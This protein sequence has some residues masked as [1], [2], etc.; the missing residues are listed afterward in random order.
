MGVVSHIFFQSD[1]TS[2]LINI[3]R[4]EI[5][6]FDASG[7]RGSDCYLFQPAGAIA[8]GHASYATVTHAFLHRQFD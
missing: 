1:F 4:R 2:L 8:D 5:H 6:D 3:K 7:E